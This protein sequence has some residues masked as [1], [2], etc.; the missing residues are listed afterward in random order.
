MT[1]WLLARRA[2][3][4][5][6]SA[7]RARGGHR[8]G[9]TLV[10][11][12]AVI[13]IVTVII[14]LVLPSLRGARRAA[15]DSAQL[16]VL[17]DL[18][19]ASTAYADEHGGV[20]PYLQTPG[21]PQVRRTIDEYEFSFGYFTAQKWLWSNL[22]WPA[23]LDAKRSSIERPE[24]REY[25]VEVRGYPP[26]VV[27]SDYVLTYNAAARPAYWR[28]RRAGEPDLLSFLNLRPALLHEVRFPADKGLV[29]RG[30][31]FSFADER[32]LA[33]YATADGG[34]V[35]H[36]YRDFDPA[37]VVDRPW[38]ADAIAVLSTRDGFE[39]RDR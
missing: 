13:A 35:S 33:F 21:A 9:F 24:V 36:P 7:T 23:Y 19:H 27:V 17:R 6:V 29:I 12:L 22:I 5:G 15:R 34:A 30:E 11:L 25:N 4:A 10:E 8:A 16:A 31:G 32:G 3:R 2:T 20:L 37:N 28:L 1:L 18:H 38:G 14:A 39:G 26:G